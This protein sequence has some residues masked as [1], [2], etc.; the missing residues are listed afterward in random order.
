M[1]NEDKQYWTQHAGHPSDLDDLVNER[2]KEHWELYGS[3]F[4]ATAPGKDPLFCQVVTRGG[5]A[6]TQ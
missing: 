6:G 1:E 3:P 2:L 4:V 5:V